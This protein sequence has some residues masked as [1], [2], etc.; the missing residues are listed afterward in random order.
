MI[1]TKQNTMNASDPSKQT[2]DH[3]VEGKKAWVRAHVFIRRQPAR[4][5]RAFSGEKRIHAEE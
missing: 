3:V 1:E 2:I 5:A 4:A